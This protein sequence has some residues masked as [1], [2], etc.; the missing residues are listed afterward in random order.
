MAYFGV[1]FSLDVPSANF[2]PGKV[3]RRIR[4]VVV[5]EERAVGLFV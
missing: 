3:N 1:E 2:E 4:V 5:S